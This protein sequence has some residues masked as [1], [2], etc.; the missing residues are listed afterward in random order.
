MKNYDMNFKIDRTDFTDS[1]NKFFDNEGKYLYIES[2]VVSLVTLYHIAPVEELS[3]HIFT[4]ETI[5]K[6][7]ALRLSETPELKKIL[8]IVLQADIREHLKIYILQECFAASQLDFVMLAANVLELRAKNPELHF[9]FTN[10]AK[11][12]ITG[13]KT[14][15]KQLTKEDLANMDKV[16]E[17]MRN[18]EEKTKEWVDNLLKNIKND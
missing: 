15:I 10:M 9:L 18:K 13:Q 3:L 17:E 5:Q 14:E 12:V 4:L 11:N 1:E 6:G 16:E 2:R 7:I 8:S